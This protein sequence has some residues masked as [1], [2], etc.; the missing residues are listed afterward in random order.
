[1]IPLW[2]SAFL[3]GCLII[4]ISQG[5]KAQCGGTTQSITY[6]TLIAGTGNTSHIFTLPQFQPSI[7]TLQSA[8][9]NSTISLNYGFMLK[10]MEFVQ[11]DF[12]VS[13]GRYDHY[14]SSALSS[15]YTNLIDTSIG[16][17]VLNPGDSVSE[18]P[19]P[20][21]SNYSLNDS[22]NGNIVNFLGSSTVAFNYTPI[23]YTNL[24]GSNIYYYSATASDTIHFSITYYYCNNIILANDIISFSAVKINPENIKLSWAMADPQ[25]GRNYGVQ[26]SADGV[27][28]A[29]VAS[30][31][32][33]GSVNY[34]YD[35]AVTAHD[36][37]AIYF[38]LKIISSSGKVTYSEIK[39]VDIIHDNS[40]NGISIYPNPS[41]SYINILFAE[42]PPNGNWDIS[43]YAASGRLIQ[44][45]H[46]AAESTAHIN[47]KNKLPAGV[48]F[49]RAES[50]ETQKKYLQ[51]FLVR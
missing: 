14:T 35:Y 33:D 42:E 9:I 28:F 21:L 24:I 17:F 12:S 25:T 43:I 26:E 6:D 18:I 2:K 16:S 19:H 41:D 29:D 37:G 49:V 31:L 46:F 51:S 44:K 8:K 38:R 27:R 32:D 50:I 15:P 30:V 10:N 39:T 40:D 1:M 7:G 11:R 47:F 23:T 34:Q 13:V 48:Y 36:H 4:Y 22:L 3:G 45:N 20:I 5:A